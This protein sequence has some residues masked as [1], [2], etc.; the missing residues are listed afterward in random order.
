MSKETRLK[1][2]LRIRQLRK[3]YGYT[4]EKLSELSEIDYKHI[5]LLESK[6]PPAIKIDTLE[7]IA[8]AFNM[9]I[10]KFLDFN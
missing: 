7:K 8:K 2:G 4:Q 10:S 6:R 9:S 3:K 1:L 5:Q